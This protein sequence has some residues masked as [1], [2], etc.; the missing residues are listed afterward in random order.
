MSE[1]VKI[2]TVG[3]SKN[4]PNKKDPNK[5]WTSWSLQFEGDANW[6]DTFWLAKE[7]PE[8]GQELSGEKKYDEKWGYKFEVERQGGK[9][10]WNPAAAQATVM[11]AAAAVVSGFL[12][13]PPH[14]KLWAS[15]VEEDAKQ[16]KPLFD[17]Y[18]ITV[19]TVA[20]R[21]KESVASMGS[22]NAE[23]KSATK[24]SS[25]SGDPGP[26]PPPGAPGKWPPE[27]EDVDL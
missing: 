19:E 13:I 21:L 12:N 5:P 10:N 8:V 2:Q 24:T 14:Y 7:L 23:E 20:K 27:E 15:S 1:K 25:G 26:T 6:Y 4:I 9:A 3:P 16:L 18:L 17:K 11:S 22:I